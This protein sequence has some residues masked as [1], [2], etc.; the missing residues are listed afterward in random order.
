MAHITSK[1]TRSQVKQARISSA[2]FPP[3]AKYVKQSLDQ[4]FQWLFS[5]A[6]PGEQAGFIFV[7]PHKYA[8]C[9][10][11]IREI[12]K[13]NTRPDNVLGWYIAVAL[14]YQLRTGAKSLSIMELA[15]H[16]N[17]DTTTVRRYLA[18]LFE[19][20]LLVRRADRRIGLGPNA[21]VVLHGNRI[22]KGQVA[23]KVNAASVRRYLVRASECHTASVG[24]A[25]PIAIDQV[26]W[27]DY[28]YCLANYFA[29]QV[30]GYAPPLEGCSRTERRFAERLFTF[31]GGLAERVY[32]W[33]R[34]RPVRSEGKR[35]DAVA[36]SAT[37]KAEIERIKQSLIANTT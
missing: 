4:G 11:R 35:L 36:D 30:K 9:R 24:T 18:L 15:D 3:V 20:H 26:L 6:E 27:R 2:G 31:F 19:T 29:S 21:P 5:D 33:K 13:D 32:A 16:T 8:K 22:Q 37:A 17:R 1:T 34:N 25:K 28:A 23:V 10:E 7:D 12:A 14:L